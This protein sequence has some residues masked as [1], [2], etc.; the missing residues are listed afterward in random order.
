MNPTNSPQGYH[1][2]SSPG[3]FSS[4]QNDDE[5]SEVNDKLDNRKKISLRN[6]KRSHVGYDH[7]FEVSNFPMYNNDQLAQII[8]DLQGEDLKKISQALE[9]LHK[10]NRETYQLFVTL[11]G[12]DVLIQF[13]E[14]I[15]PLNVINQVL[16]IICNLTTLKDSS[17][18]T[19]L[20]GGYFLSDPLFF[21]C[22]SSIL[23]FIM[24]TTF[25]PENDPRIPVILCTFQSTSLVTTI[26]RFLNTIIVSNQIGSFNVSLRRCIVILTNLIFDSADLSRDILNSNILSTVLSVVELLPIDTLTELVF[27]LQNL[28]ASPREIVQSAIKFNIPRFVLSFLHGLTDSSD[29]SKSLWILTNFL[30][31][32]QTGLVLQQI[33]DLD[34]ISSIEKLKESYQSQCKSHATILLLEYQ[35]RDQA[36]RLK[37]QRLELSR[38]GEIIPDADDLTNQ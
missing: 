33:K 12:I 26:L 23:H 1:P 19:I 8:T 30:R 6:S 17:P 32:D 10:S 35:R 37:A 25:Y 27:L 18:D 28:S 34:L 11:N 15:P 24:A 38:R 4:L 16:T 21:D 7:F 29:M 3:R 14:K 22:S 2:P 31:K 9:T 36:F 13:L 5:Q 20:L